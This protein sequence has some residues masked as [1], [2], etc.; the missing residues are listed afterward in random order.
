MQVEASESSHCL[1]RN[2]HCNLFHLCS[3]P[4]FLYSRL[5]INT[6]LL[7]VSENYVKTLCYSNSTLF[8]FSPSSRT[9]FL[10]MYHYHHINKSL[11]GR[12]SKRMAWF[13]TLQNCFLKPLTLCMHILWP[14]C[15]ARTLIKHFNFNNQ[16]SMLSPIKWIGKEYES[17]FNQK[18][19]HRLFRFSLT[20]E[21]GLRLASGQLL[22]KLQLKSI[23][24][25]SYEFSTLRQMT[26]KM[27]KIY[28]NYFSFSP[29]KLIAFSVLW[30]M[31]LLFSRVN[32]YFLL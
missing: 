30:F 11:R 14:L 23:N 5:L 22:S 26:K 31:M 3:T 24:C 17:W 7:C 13:I 16:M 8:H 19:K 1:S 25:H 21:F 2:S 27:T 18:T 9:Y 4:V 32:R 6:I 15:S 20:R 29:E 12:E 10:C 28:L